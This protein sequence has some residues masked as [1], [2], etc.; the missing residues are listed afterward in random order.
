MNFFKIIL[1]SI[2]LGLIL[3]TGI[4]SADNIIRVFT[5]EGYV[6]PEEV[7]AVNKLLKKKGYDYKVEVIKPWAKGPEHMFSII[8]M[9]NVHKVDISF[10]TLNYIKMQRS[11]IV[12]VLKPVNIKSPRLTNYKHLLKSLTDIGIGMDKNKHY[13]VPW[14]GGAYGIWADM[15]KLKKSDLPVSL[16]D[17]WHPRWKGKISLTSGQVQPNLAI[18]FLSMGQPPFYLNDIGKNRT[19]LQQKGSP[20]SDIQKKV[21]GLYSQ[22]GKFWDS[23]PL[24][25]NDFLLVASY[26]PGAAMENAK[27]GKWKLLKFKEGN[28][29]WLDTMNFHKKLK[30]EKLKAAEIFVNYF[31]GKKVQNR[32]VKG[33]GMVAASSLIKDNVLLNENPNFFEERMFWPPYV[34]RADNMMLTISKRAMRANGK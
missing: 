25:S 19:L 24:F 8:R 22:V 34:K 28:T 32:V 31:I 5:W 11:K 1:L 23:G 7:K 18:C 29:V 13:Y 16:T 21:T 9:Y 15:K 17:L 33:L 20:N 6:I 4:L 30:G 26:G 3:S 27:G 2:V 10:L 12:K 14:G